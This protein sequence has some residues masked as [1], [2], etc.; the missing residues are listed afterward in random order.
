MSQKEMEENFMEEKWMKP[1]ESN[2]QWEEGSK[3]AREEWREGE[4]MDGR[5]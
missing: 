2:F 3:D 4:K 5:N 1:L